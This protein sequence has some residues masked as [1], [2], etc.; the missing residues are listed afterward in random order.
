MRTQSDLTLRLVLF[1]LLVGFPGAISAQ[2]GSEKYSNG[3]PDAAKNGFRSDEIQRRTYAISLVLSLTDEAQVYDDL[4]LRSRVLSQAADTLWNADNMI[5][6]SLFRRA[7]EAA[8]KGDAE[9]VTVK[10]T[11]NPPPMVIGLRRSSGRDL[12]AEVLTLAARRDRTLGEEFLA[13][14][15]ASEQATAAENKDSANRS[16]SFNGPEASAKRLQI[17]RRLL[18]EN[19]VERALQFATPALNEINAS[20]IG[21]L[22]ALRA[23]NADLA[24]QSFTALLTHAALDPNADANTVSGLSSYVLTPGVYVT[25]NSDGG[26]RW[27]QPDASLPPPNLPV[28]LRRRCR[29]LSEHL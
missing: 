17:A 7:W 14:L 5:A 6:R 25:F 19:E 10:T 26:A 24:D 22:S 18:D 23:K 9:K 15:N 4:A 3:I 29:H 2:E 8:D 27:T 21:F 11:D 1:V 16:D 13:K 28:E 20:S 12:R